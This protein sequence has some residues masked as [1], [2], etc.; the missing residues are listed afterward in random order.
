MIQDL[1]K[2]KE[3]FLAGDIDAEDYEDNLQRIKEWESDLR[4]SEDFLGWQGSDV[5]KQILRQAREAYKDLGLQLATSRSLTEAERYGLWGKQDAALWLIS[6][7]AKDAKSEIA[8]IH[9][10]IRQAL[11]AG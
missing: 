11:N 4:K 9:G 2:L 7:I 3:I 8:Q 10:Q 1:E 5:S 6:M